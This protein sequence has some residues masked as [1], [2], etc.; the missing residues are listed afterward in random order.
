MTGEPWSWSNW[1]QTGNPE[2]NGGT[3]ENWGEFGQFGNAN[4]WND[5]MNIAGRAD[6]GDFH[7]LLEKSF[8]YNLVASCSHRWLW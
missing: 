8:T 4:T 2:P 5:M 1:R 7:Y 3:R 6:I